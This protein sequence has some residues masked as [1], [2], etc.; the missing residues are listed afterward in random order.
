MVIFVLLLTR[1]IIFIERYG[2]RPIGYRY[3]RLYDIMSTFILWENLINESHMESRNGL[4]PEFR[5]HKGLAR[6]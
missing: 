6:G 5:S 1:S 2:Y 4:N 3:C